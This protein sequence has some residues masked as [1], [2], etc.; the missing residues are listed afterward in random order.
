MCE[1]ILIVDASLDHTA[2]WPVQQW[3]PYLGGAPADAVH[4]PSTSAVPSLSRYTHIL[5][6]GS[7]ATFEE[8]APWF[9]LEADL[10]RDAVDRDLA[11]LGSCFGHQMLVWALSGP[12]SVRR[13]QCP[14]LGW[15]SIEIL[16]KDQLLDDL[17]N[18]WHAFAFH[19]DE[20]IAPPSP[21]RVLAKNDACSVQAIR[22]GDQR[23]WGIQPHPE[24]DP[25]E[26]R[27]LMEMALRQAPDRAEEIRRAMS[28]P[29]CDD[30]VTAQLV[31]SFLQS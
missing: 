13:A 22:Y 16:G 11:V 8:P 3:I 15:V 31:D 23:V 25:P 19:L 10:V 4:L 14:E 9:E 1:R 7:E 26:A 29:V 5:L 12:Q 20:V 30:A 27:R 6:T 18:P 24:T 21:W 17:P 2:Y 28:Q